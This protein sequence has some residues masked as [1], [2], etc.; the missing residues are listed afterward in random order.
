M[1]NTVNLVGNLGKDAEL[2]HTGTTAVAEFSLATTEKYKGES[3]TQWHN[4]VLFGKVADA[5]SQYLK[6]GK[7][8]YVSG[9]IYYQSWDKKDG[10]KGYKTVIKAFQVQM[11]GSRDDS[12]MDRQDQKFQEQVSA[13]IP[14]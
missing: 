4:I 1:I 6:K 10:T 2:K 13:E 9:S 5:L 12:G 3:K 7:Q 14:F 8:V 11:L